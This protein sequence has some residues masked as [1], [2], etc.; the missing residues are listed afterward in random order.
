MSEV[1]RLSRERAE[2]TTASRTPSRSALVA[3]AG[4]A[5]TRRPA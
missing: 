1:Q 4:D 3:A 2:L 5:L